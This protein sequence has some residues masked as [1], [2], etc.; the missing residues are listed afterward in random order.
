M[1][2]AEW[3]FLC[4]FNSFKIFLNVIIMVWRIHKQEQTLYRWN[5]I[6]DVEPYEW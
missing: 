3:G 5:G 6:G 4:L 1:H 2:M